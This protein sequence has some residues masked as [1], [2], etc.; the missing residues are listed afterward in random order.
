MNFVLKYDKKKNIRFSS[1]NV[2][3]AAARF[4]KCLLLRNKSGYLISDQTTL[5][6]SYINSNALVKPLQS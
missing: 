6:A 5:I 1:I 3:L 4:V 2:C